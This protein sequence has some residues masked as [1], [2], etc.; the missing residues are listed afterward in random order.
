LMIDVAAIV[1]FGAAQCIQ[2]VRGGR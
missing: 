1:V 2:S